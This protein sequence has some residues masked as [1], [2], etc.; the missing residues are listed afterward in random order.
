[1]DLARNLLPGEN[2]RQFHHPHVWAE[3]YPVIFLS[4]VDDYHKYVGDARVAG[5]GETFVQ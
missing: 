2:V 1:M 3:F 5:V 4:C